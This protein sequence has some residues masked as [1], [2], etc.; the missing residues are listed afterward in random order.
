MPRILW[1]SINLYM[2]ENKLP[3]RVRGRKI[4]QA[5]L[6]LRIVCLPT[7][8]RKKDLRKTQGGAPG[9]SVG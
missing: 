7:S 3:M 6:E 4:L 1:Q 5:Q 9:D 8:Q 2:S